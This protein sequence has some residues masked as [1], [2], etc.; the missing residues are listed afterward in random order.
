MRFRLWDDECLPTT[1]L[2][3]NVKLGI[4]V[5]TTESI[6]LIRK[7]FCLLFFAQLQ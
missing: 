3:L 5:L 4:G 1:Y 7:L 2:I 6:K